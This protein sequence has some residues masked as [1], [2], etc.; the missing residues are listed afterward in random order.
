M[1]HLARPAA[2][3]VALM[4]TV[5]VASAQQPAPTPAPAPAPSTQPAQGALPALAPSHLAVAREVAVGSGITRS[6]E[7]IPPQLYD[8]IREQNVTR[9][10]LTKD[11]EEVLKALLPEMELQ[12]QRMIA[13]VAA[14][15]ARQMTEAELK[16]VIAFFRSPSGK[17][18]VETQ[19]MVLDDLVREMQLWSQ[20]LA[21]YVMV[22]LRAE[23]GKRGHQ[24]Q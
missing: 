10:E 11:L 18:Y 20:E 4:L 12:K 14:I 17:K 19:P 9:P 8:R 15:Y 5:G 6:L 1:P 21:E 24:L 7:I 13:I 16:D 2:W 22:R 3:L 23:M